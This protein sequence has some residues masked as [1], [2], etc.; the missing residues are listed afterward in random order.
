M[1]KQQMG[2]A[3][4]SGGDQVLADLQSTALA[5]AAKARRG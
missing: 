2:K 3:V 4:K 5:E 1:I